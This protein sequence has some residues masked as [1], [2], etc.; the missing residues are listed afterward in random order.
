[1]NKCTVSTDDISFWTGFYK[2]DDPITW[3]SEK[4]YLDMNRTMTFRESDSGKTEKEKRAIQ[5]KR[6][7]YRDKVTNIIS[8][9]IAQSKEK[10]DDFDT[11]HKETCNMI[12][13]YYGKTLDDGQLILVCRKGKERSVKGTTLSVGQAQKWL[14]M[15]LKYLWLLDRLNLLEGDSSSFV[16]KYQFCFHIPLDS[17]I[18]RYVKRE[19]KS[20]KCKDFPEANGLLKPYSIEGLSGSQWSRID[21]YERYLKYQKA[22]RD[23]LSSQGKLPIEWELEHWHKAVAYYDELSNRTFAHGRTTSLLR[24][25]QVCPKPTIL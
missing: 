3:A 6:Y 23:D 12:I 15:T 19:P 16:C 14:N 9:R 8:D 7:D 5:E 24:A 21:D 13:D 18:I 10:S 11:W 20:N 4:A 1:M 25:E 17:Y 2:N 22:I